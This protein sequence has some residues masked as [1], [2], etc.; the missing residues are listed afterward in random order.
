MLHAEWHSTKECRE[1]E[2]TVEAGA[3]WP[4]MYEPDFYILWRDHGI[5]HPR[6]GAMFRKA[7]RTEPPAEPI[8]LVRKAGLRLAGR[9]I[10]GGIICI[11]E[12]TAENE[13]AHV[14]YRPPV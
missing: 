7:G 13:T 4:P 8:N 5:A 12:N 6:Y 11:P 2:E 9:S 14:E 10:T 3:Q 1:Y